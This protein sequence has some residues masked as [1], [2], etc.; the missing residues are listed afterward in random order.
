VNQS[1]DKKPVP[2]ALRSALLLPNDS[3]AA[4]ITS[5][6]P[7]NLAAAL[8]FAEQGRRQIRARQ[9]HK[10]VGYFERAVSLGLRSYLPYIYYYLAQTHHHLANYQYAFDFLDVAEPW[11]A[12]YTDWM[13]SIA[14]LRQDNINAMGYAQTFSGSKTR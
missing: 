4:K 2:P 9:Y 11:L 10:A 7:S 12:E 5:R 1:G 8:R 3:F 14:A 13:T 6:T